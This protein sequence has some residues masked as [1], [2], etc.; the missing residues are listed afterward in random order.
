MD[1]L[2]CQTSAASPAEPGEL[3]FFLAVRRC[4]PCNRRTLCCR[5]PL[6]CWHSFWF[7]GRRSPG[8]DKLRR[9]EAPVHKRSARE[10]METASRG[11]EVCTCTLTF[12]QGSRSICRA[13]ANR[14]VPSQGERV[15]SSHRRAANTGNLLRCIGRSRSARNSSAPSFQKRTPKGAGHDRLSRRVSQTFGAEVGK[16]N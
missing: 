16:S 11:T 8:F 3:L 14:E 7:L 6:P 13:V 1:F 12:A 5:R 15:R 2:I 4:G 9:P 10:K